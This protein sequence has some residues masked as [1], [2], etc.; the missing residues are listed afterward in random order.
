MLR[1]LHAERG[2]NGILRRYQ[3]PRLG[4]VETITTWR[5]PGA[6]II[7]IETERDRQ[8]WRAMVDRLLDRPA[9]RKSRSKSTVKKA[10]NGR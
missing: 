5:E 8:K 3:H 7:R 10:C 6:L 9:K 2:P 4:L 1:L